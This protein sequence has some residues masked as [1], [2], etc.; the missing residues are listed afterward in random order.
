[1]WGVVERQLAYA[2]DWRAYQSLG[3]IGL[4]EIARLKGHGDFIAI[5]SARLPNGQLTVLAILPDRK[6]DTVKAFFASIPV[7]L[8]ATITSVCTDLYEGYLQAARDMLPGVRRVIDRFHVARLYRAA[9]DD[10]RKAELKRLKA[11]LPAN[12]YRT[13][14]GT[15][16]AFRLAPADLQPE[17]KQLL[18]YLFALSP[19]LK[20]VYQLREAL[21]AIFDHATTRRSAQ[22]QI[23]AWQRQVQRTELPY[24]DTFL[25][26]LDRFWEEITNYFVA[27]ETSSFVEGLN[28]KIKVLT[29]RS[30]GLYNLDHLFQRLFLDLH[31][32]RLFA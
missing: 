2:V 8:R 22:K 29:R 13:L 3:V 19:T 17:Q 21:T 27:G 18:T 1:V 32:Y 7:A 14:K 16:W 28:N 5:V 12:Q 20:Q 6:K 4:D 24:F 10:C 23:R 15:L 9:A 25:A 30:Y 26:T 11:T 31:G